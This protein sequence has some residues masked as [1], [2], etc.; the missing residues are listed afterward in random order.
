MWE[1]RQDFNFS[2]KLSFSILHTNISVIFICKNECNTINH[3][4]ERLS[5]KAC[6]YPHLNNYHVS[7]LSMTTGFSP[8]LKVWLF[9]TAINTRLFVGQHVVKT[10]SIS[11]PLHWSHTRMGTLYGQFGEE[12]WCQRRLHMACKYCVRY[13]S[14]PKNPN[15]SRMIS[16]NPVF[17][18]RRL[19][20]IYR[21]NL[22][23]KT[24]SLHSSIVPVTKG[25]CVT[26]SIAL[27][28]TLPVVH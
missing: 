21:T 15:L 6:R 10:I 12:E 3:F 8:N 20:R 13:T 2:P 5:K 9:E 22:F 27:R 17:D 28:I 4:N 7:P 23:C 26:T 1:S 19:A 18:F 16:L 14:L 25:S 24:L 11:P